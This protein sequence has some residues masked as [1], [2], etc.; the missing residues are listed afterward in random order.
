MMADDDACQNDPQARIARLEAALEE[1]RMTVY[2]TSAMV[3][4]REEI[5]GLQ[6]GREAFLAPTDE[7]VELTEAEL[8]RAR[9]RIR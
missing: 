4:S 1:A 5:L 9:A 6:L 2:Y 7:H 3:F 8:E